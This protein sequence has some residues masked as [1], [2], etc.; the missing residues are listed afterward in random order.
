MPGIHD[1]GP[2]QHHGIPE[3]SVSPERGEPGEGT[4]Q[5]GCRVLGHG[6]T[7]PGD[8]LHLHRR[9]PLAHDPSEGIHTRQ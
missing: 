7:E 1:P 3:E 6:M 2:G 5:N 8:P 9:A 4:I